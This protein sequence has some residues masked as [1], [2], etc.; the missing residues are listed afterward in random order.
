MYGIT[1]A[2]GLCYNYSIYSY[3]LC[4]HVYGPAY[5]DDDNDDNN[6]DDDNCDDDYDGDDCILSHNPYLKYA[7]T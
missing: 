2:L 6:G 3:N 4:L 5:Y 7:Q 1:K